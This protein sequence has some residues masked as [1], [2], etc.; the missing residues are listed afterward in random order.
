[1]RSDKDN[2]IKYRKVNYPHELDELIDQPC[3]PSKF[4][5][6]MDNAI[7]AFTWLA[8]VIMSAYPVH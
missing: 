4:K 5:E 7:L 8:K 2:K 1:M 3:H 6:Y